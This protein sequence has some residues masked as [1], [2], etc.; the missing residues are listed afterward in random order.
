V[1]DKRTEA[2]QWIDR[3]PALRNLTDRQQ[4]LARLL[5]Q[6]Q[7]VDEIASMLGVSVAT[8]TDRLSLSSKWTIATVVGKISATTSKAANDRP[9]GKA[10]AVG[11]NGTDTVG[12]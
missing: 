4:E 9:G 3:D 8:L 10:G 6:G 2:Q 5:A 1:K 7:T 12:P 11:R